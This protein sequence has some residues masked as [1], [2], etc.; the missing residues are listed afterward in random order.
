MSNTRTTR[1]WGRVLSRFG[2]RDWVP[3][4]VGGGLCVK[5]T[6]NLLNHVGFK[7]ADVLEN[8]S[9]NLTYE[10]NS[11]GLV[12]VNIHSLDGVC[13][14]E[15]QSVKAQKHQNRRWKRRRKNKQVVV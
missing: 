12:A 2:S 9:V 3:V 13:A 14:S 10:H 11:H 1:A 8:V 4:D 15:R 6:L 7:R 5:M